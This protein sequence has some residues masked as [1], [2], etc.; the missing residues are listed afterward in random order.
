MGWRLNACLADPSRLHRLDDGFANAILMQRDHF[1][2]A[3]FLLH[4][5][6]DDLGDD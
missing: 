2:H 4:A 6:V 1:G 5:I 3:D